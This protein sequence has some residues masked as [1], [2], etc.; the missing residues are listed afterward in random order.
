MACQ[1]PYVTTANHQGFGGQ[2]H[3]VEQTVGGF[4]NQICLSYIWTTVTFRIPLG[5]YLPTDLP[6]KLPKCR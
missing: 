2:P 5:M 3:F 1:N 4:D 6:P